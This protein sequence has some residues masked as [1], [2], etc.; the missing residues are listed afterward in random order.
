MNAWATMENYMTLFG[1]NV[2][3]ACTES[4]HI[5]KLTSSDMILF[6]GNSKV[7]QAMYSVLL[8]ACFPP[9]KV[10]VFLLLVEHHFKRM[11][12]EPNIRH[13]YQFPN[14]PSLE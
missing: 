14:V 8:L 13:K 10:F 4:Q 6:H 2:L 11:L 7:R 9:C 3:V 5:T 12:K 1:E